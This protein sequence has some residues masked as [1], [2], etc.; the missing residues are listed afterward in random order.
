[1][2]RVL[3]IA[4][5]LIFSSAGLVSAQTV[6]SQ[7]ITGV[8]TDPSGAAVP[9]A[10]VTVT[11]E[12]TRANHVV[13][14]NESGNYTVLNL[15]VGVYTITTTMQGFKK[16]ILSGVNVD[17]G[18][19]PSIPVQLEIGMATE[20]VSV[21]ADSVLI[22]TTSAEIG[23]V[24]TSQEATQIQLNG[25]NYIQLLTLQPGVSQ[26]VASG[27]ALFGTYG[28]SGSSQ[29]VNGIRTDSANYFIDGVD[30][31]DNGGGGNN[32]VNISPDSLQQFRN[33]ASGYDAS[34]GGTSGATVSVAIKSGGRDFHGSAY[35]YLRNDAVQA[36][37]F[38][39]LSSLTQAPIKA[40]LRYNDFGYTIGGPIWIPGVFNRN[41]DKLFFFA[42]QEYKR[43]RTST[44]TNASVPR[45]TDITAAINNTN[46]NLAAGPATATGRALAATLLQ[47]PS[48]NYRYLS[49]G[50]NNQSE[51]LVKIDYAL[52]E[53]NQISGRFVH[54]NVLNVGNPTNYLIY[55]RT[56]PGLTSSVSWTHTFNS[57]TVNVA[58]GSYSGN[59]INEGGNIRANS[60]FGSRPINR[61][62]YGLT[63][64][65][66]YNASPLIPQITISGLGNPGF[67]PRQFDN[68]QRIYALKDDF[69]RV[70]GNHSVKLGAY[71]WRAR[72][73]Q[74]A[75]PQLNGAFNFADTVTKV[76]D[77][78]TNLP[79]TVSA[80]QNLVRGNFASYTEGSNIPQVQARFAQFETYVQDDWTVSRRLTLNLGLRW[81]YMPP[82]SS[83]P[84]NTAFF[85]P[86][87]Y[88]PTKAATVSPT[89]GLVT[90]APAPYNGLV[91]PGSGF[92]DK[93]KQVVAPSVYNNP[94][95]LALFRGAPGGIV[96]TVYNTFAPRVGFAYDLTGKQQTVLHG[97]YGMSYERVEGNYIYGAVSQLPFTAV[98][99]LASA[100]NVDTLASIGTSAAPTNISNSGDRNL[101]PPRIQN[102]SIGL[103]HKL[104]ENTSV[105]ANYVGARSSN[106]T[107]RKNLNQGAA[108]IENAN[109]GVSRNALRPYKGYGEI[110]QYTNGSRLNYNSLQARMQTRFSKGGL[111]NLS[112]TWS[113]ALTD[114]STFDYQP[115]DSNNLYA[116]YGPA[117]YN[118]PKIFV[119]SYVYPL[120]FWQHEHE[121]YKQAAGGWQLSGITRISSGLPIN[122][123]Q[124]SGISNAG[125]LVT[126][127]NVAQRPNLVGDPYAHN[128]KQYLNPAAFAVPAAGT[129]GNLGYDA[130]KGPLFN[131]WDLAVQKNI[132]IHE[133]VGL[134]FRA[135]MFN[136][137]NHLSG[138]V[139]GNTLGAAQANGS[140]QTNFSSTG[141]FQNSFGQFTSTTDPRTMEFVLRASF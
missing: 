32:F 39:A 90:A 120:P 84:N 130:I 1:M 131:N 60:Q 65:T 139:V 105:E 43:L 42:A 98:A 141:A 23:G 35:E 128:G 4:L 70:I 22:Q 100:G 46:A 3:L 5:L 2:K 69:S 37:P 123:I 87:Y 114:G 11:N 95:V 88:D 54:D 76:I 57:K 31:K 10:E 103:Q 24:V 30:N 83:W 107:Y 9:Q 116:D 109:P 15:P 104:F 92:S 45:A 66:L 64:K 117:N 52:N 72:K 13:V 67:S 108:G 140:Y 61:S 26:T 47:D 80:V 21:K 18:G 6:D 121:W 136:V 79:I 132:S 49:L 17:V 44:V 7:L 124:P 8:V 48:G 58:T 91:L 135:E 53:K 82:I 77:P 96:N 50:N 110:Y 78:V 59:I 99:S 55:D 51:Y 14:S 133:R 93:A 56:I 28:V 111:V 137:P 74:T 63:Y 102:Y 86:A 25:R 29:S 118:Q 138:F 85:D 89:S 81:Q 126:T 20:S 119:A 68:S 94:A 115:Q 101:A 19:K 134:E 27:F 41:R 40:P 129:Y 16:S 97:G 122:V 36:Y 12:A 33:V 75:P 127:A 113:K 73:N 125:N 38:R 62:D 112:F 34:Y 106:L 71:F